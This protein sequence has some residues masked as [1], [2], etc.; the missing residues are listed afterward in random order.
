MADQITIAVTVSSAS[1]VRKENGGIICMP[2]TTPMAAANA[3]TPLAASNGKAA[4]DG[5]MNVR[6][7]KITAAAQ[8]MVVTGSQPPHSAR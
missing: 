5:A 8:R 1:I 3:D 6:I 7:K 4:D 2:N